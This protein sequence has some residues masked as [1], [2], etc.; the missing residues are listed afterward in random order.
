[1]AAGQYTA[2]VRVRG[3]AATARSANDLLQLTLGSA[4]LAAGAVFIRRSAN[5]EAPTADPRFR[6]TEQLRV[7]IP[8]AVDETATARL[9]DRTGT[10]I[11]VPIA[12]A[13][14]DADG[15]RWHTAQFALAPLAAGD[16]VIEV[17]TAAGGSGI[18]ARPGSETIARQML[19]FRVL[20]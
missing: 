11:P 7:E 16:Y 12:I 10:P 14:R 15:V 2:R 4:P 9:L 18:T 17:S 13:A 5:R 19:A 3:R 6:R 20:P 1:L 8:A